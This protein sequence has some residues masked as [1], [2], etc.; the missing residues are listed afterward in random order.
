MFIRRLRGLFATIVGGTLV[1]G[2]AGTVIG[3]LFWLAPG[4][5]TVTIT[6]HFP[7]AIIIVP[8]TW[9]AAIGALSGAAFGVLLMFAER[10]RDIRDLRAYKVATWAALTSAPALWFGGASWSLVAIGSGL[11]AVIGLG[12]TLLAKRGRDAAATGDIHSF[13]G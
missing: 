7:G 9:G 10:G 3:L 12:A 4:P 5:K 2:T 11:A 6:P 13:R 1:G 8:A